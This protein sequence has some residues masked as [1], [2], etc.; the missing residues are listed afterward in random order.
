[1]SGKLQEMLEEFRNDEKWNT[2]EPGGGRRFDKKLAWLEGMVKSY[3]QKLGLSEDR[4]AEIMEEKRTYSWPNYYKSANFPG[5]D[6]ENLIGVFQ[7]FEAY[8]EHARKHW[9]GFI[10]PKCGNISQHPQEC[11]HRIEKDGKCDWCSYGLFN[12]QRGVIILEH[13]L[14]FIPI[15][16]PVEKEA[17]T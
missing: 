8:R 6:S 14:N 16:E 5:F 1:M 4:V 17:T 9:K 7:T 2:P 12:S 10:C 3:A 15:F 13:G 11:F